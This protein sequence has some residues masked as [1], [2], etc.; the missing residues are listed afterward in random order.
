VIRYRISCVIPVYNGERFLA[1]ALDSVLAQTRPPEEIVVVDD[2][3]TDDTPRVAAR[4]AGQVHYLRQDNRGHAAARNRGIEATSGELVAFLDA[5]DLWHP[6]KLA[7]QAERF[8]ARADL[9]I[10]STLIR[11]FWVA[12]LQAEQS[13]LR[14]HFLTRDMPG[15]MPSAVT[16]R[17]SAFRRLGGFDETMKHKALIEW[18]AR[19]AR[20]AAV[21]E[22]LPAV[23]TFRRIHES[24]M[25]RTKA[26]RDAAE[27]LEVA[28]AMIGRHRSQPGGP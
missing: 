19:A 18:L 26:N 5:D 12:E 20:A 6:D 21:M 8:E 9:D 25:S 23:L 27:L 17:R 4:Y 15:Y 22:C 13:S 28:H 7:R 11:N 24:N 3:S 1:E 2:G 10:S 14:D 16:V